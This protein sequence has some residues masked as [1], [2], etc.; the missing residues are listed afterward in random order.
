M[1][2]RPLACDRAVCYQ[3][4]QLGGGEAGA[5]GAQKVHRETGTGIIYI[6]IYYICIYVYIKINTGSIR[7][8]FSIVE[9]LSGLQRSI[10][11]LFQTSLSSRERTNTLSTESPEFSM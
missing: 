7:M 4:D 3:G 10:F 1:T 2:R 8:E 5:Q 11:S 9:N 6:Y